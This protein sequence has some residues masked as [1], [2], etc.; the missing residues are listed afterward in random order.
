MSTKVK[1]YIFVNGVMKANPEYKKADSFGEHTPTPSPTTSSSA[2]QKKPEDVPLAVV[3]SMEDIESATKLQAVTTGSPMQLSL[4][5]TESLMNIQEDE[6][7]DGFHS[8]DGVEV[9]G[10]DI[11]DKL[12]EYFI[13]YEVLIILYSYRFDDTLNH[14][15]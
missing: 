14:L 11:I 1:K 5:T 9:D 13:Q 2:K 3:C 10:G 12:S 8:P 7:L 6:F 15:L 4:Q